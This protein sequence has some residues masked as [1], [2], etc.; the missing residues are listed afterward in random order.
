MLLH[1]ILRYLSFTALVLIMVFVGVLLFEPILLVIFLTVVIFLW[2]PAMIAISEQGFTD[3]FSEVSLLQFLLTI[4]ASIF[5]AMILFWKAFVIWKA[6][7]NYQ[8]TAKRNFLLFLLSFT[9]FTTL[10]FLATDA[11]LYSILDDESNAEDVLSLAEYIIASTMLGLIFLAIPLFYNS[12]LKKK[13]IQTKTENV[14]HE[15]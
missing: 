8:P 11:G 13:Q 7:K 12:Q 10:Q 6:F 2:P 15:L 5:L 1:S 14:R 4:V 3:F 9:A